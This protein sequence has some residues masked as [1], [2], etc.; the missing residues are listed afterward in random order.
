L[1]SPFDRGS[2][3]FYAALLPGF[4]GIVFAFG[5]P[6]GTKLRGMRM[7]GLILVLGFSTLW[8]GSCSGSNNSSSSN[9]GTPAGSYT[10]T[11]N[12][13]TGGTNALTSSTTFTLTVN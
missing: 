12:G 2:R 13:T 11:V 4:I 6:K 5:S 8:L 7:L 10:I 3:I 1:R 9:P